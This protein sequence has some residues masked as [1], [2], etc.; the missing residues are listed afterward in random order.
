MRE[1]LAL[2]EY[3]DAWAGTDDLRRAAASTVMA[4]SAGVLL[5]TS[6]IPS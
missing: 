2:D 6:A 1:Q 3:L 4:L 5:L